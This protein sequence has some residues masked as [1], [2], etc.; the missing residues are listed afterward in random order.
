MLQTQNNDIF[1]LCYCKK[2]MFCTGNAVRHEFASYLSLI[3]SLKGYV[4]IQNA[5]T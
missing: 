1:M 3:C 5:L 2:E 4:Y